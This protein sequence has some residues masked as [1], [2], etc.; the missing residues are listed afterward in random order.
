MIRDEYIR[1]ATLIRIVDG[2]TVDVRVDLGCDINISM[3]VRLSGIDAPERNTEPGRAAIEWI[4]KK[5]PMRADLMVKTIK[6]RKEKYG[7]Y[8]ADIFLV[9]DDVSINQKMIEAGHARVYDGGKR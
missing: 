3:K 9:G 5:I 7:R 8:L 2:D 4:S 1:R 6:D